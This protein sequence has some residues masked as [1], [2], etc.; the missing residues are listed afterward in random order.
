[1][2]CSGR[3]LVM[4]LLLLVEGG[5]DCRAVL[6]ASSILSSWRGRGWMGSEVGCSGRLQLPLEGGTD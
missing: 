5:T 4:L 2:G 1:M 6:G 3:L